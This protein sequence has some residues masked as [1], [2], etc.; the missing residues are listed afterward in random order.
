MQ[1]LFLK[2]YRN[3]FSQSM[4]KMFIMQI[5]NDILELKSRIF[6]TKL[7]L[8]LDIFSTL[9]FNYVFLRNFRSLILTIIC[10]I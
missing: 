8:I 5:F 9:L 7:S 10:V 6:D 4:C 3:Y 2:I 1:I